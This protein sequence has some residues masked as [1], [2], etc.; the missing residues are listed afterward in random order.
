[1]IIIW[2]FVVSL[3]ITDIV[4]GRLAPQSELRVAENMLI[5]V[6]SDIYVLR[7]IMKLLSGVHARLSGDAFVSI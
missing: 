4:P 6:R 1:M 2:V 3:A 5:R 7:M